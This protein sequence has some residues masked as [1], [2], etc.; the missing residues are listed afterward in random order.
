[1]TIIFYLGLSFAALLG[2]HVL[3]EL[4]ARSLAYQEYYGPN[5]VR[6]TRGKRRLW[7][8]VGVIIVFLGSGMALG[9]LAE[10]IGVSLPSEINGYTISEVI[11]L[12]VITVFVGVAGTIG[13][14]IGDLICYD[15]M[16]EKAAD[17]LAIKGAL[18]GLRGDETS[19]EMASPEPESFAGSE[20]E[21]DYNFDESAFWDGEKKTN[22]RGFDNRHPDDADLWAKIDDENCP[23]GEQLNALRAINRRKAKRAGKTGR[24][25]VKR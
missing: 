22:P 24:D 20:G 16:Y 12:L 4:Y 19:E 18:Q 7:S 15:R 10:F 1:M 6:I 17:S 21:S 13:F 8:V 25:L 9:W 3:L 2:W 11:G 5:F 23:E 14:L